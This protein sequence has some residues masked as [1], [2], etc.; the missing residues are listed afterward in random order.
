MRYRFLTLR[1]FVVGLLAACSSDDPTAPLFSGTTVE[2]VG[3]PSDSVLLADSEV[4]LTAVV[5]S[6]DGAEVTGIPPRWTTSNASRATVT[7]DGRVTGVGPGEV[8]VR[9]S[10]GGATDQRT[11]SVR[12]R[13]PVPP[14]SGPPLATTLLDG[15]VRI[16]LGAGAVSEGTV[17][18]LR[19]VDDPPPIARL[20]SA[21]TIELGPPGVTFSAPV[22]LAISYPPSITLAEQPFLR[23]H[24]LTDGAW[25]IMPGG[26]VDLDAGRASGTITRT[27]TYGLLRPAAVATLHIDAGDG[28][29]ALAGTFVSTAPRVLVRDAEGQPVEGA[30]IRFF[31]SAGGGEIVGD[32]TGISDASGRARLS[33]QWRLGPTTTNNALTAEVVGSSVAPV[34]FSATMETVTLVLTRDIAGA[35]SGRPATTQPRLE[36]RTGS[37]GLLPISDGVT[38]QLLNGNGTLVGTL[39]VDA[40]SG[41]VTFTNLRIDGT[42]AHQLRFTAG[43]HQV[44]GGVFTVTQE[45]AALKI[46]VQ[47]AGAEEDKPFDTQPVIELLDDAGL[48]YLPEKAVTASIA[49]G[50]GD[51][52]GNRSITSSGGRVHFT[53]LRIDDDGMHRLRFATSSPTRFVL[54]DLFNVI[55]D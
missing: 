33:G 12:T 35:V 8:N 6:A 39:R 7:P 48:P 36:F 4:Q 3:A 24:R 44:T 45:L 16:T 31:V 53:N 43:G 23:L 30:V 26:S 54:S 46:V 38:A 42:G 47:P 40:A 17:L 49:S 28:Q 2:I 13:V 27:G 15:A 22:T 18:H 5:R 25:S 21:T 34:T 51:L 41:V 14:S 32:A 52:R 1:A 19:A 20:V 11:F 37:G 50:P 29:T 10:A 55:D 9:V